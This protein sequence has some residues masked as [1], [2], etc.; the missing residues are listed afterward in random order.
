MVK[1][2]ERGRGRG[3]ERE[4]EGERETIILFYINEKLYVFCVS[5]INPDK[6]ISF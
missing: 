3:S 6:V 1:E 5:E 4:G 2:R